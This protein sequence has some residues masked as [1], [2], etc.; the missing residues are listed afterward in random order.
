MKFIKTLKNSLTSSIRVLLLFSKED[1]L[2]ASR[3]SKENYVSESSFGI[4]TIF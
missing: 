2:P 1:L 4:L 3:V